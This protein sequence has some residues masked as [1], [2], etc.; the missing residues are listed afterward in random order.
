M[1]LQAAVDG[2]GV[3]LARS[4]TSADDLCERRI[5]RPFRLACATN[6]AYYLVHPT[7]LALSPAAAAF[8][9]W[10]RNEAEE[11]LKKQDFPAAQ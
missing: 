6:Y 7:G 4:V 11:F 1:A 9:G 8:C 5:I 2:Q 10:L 3:A